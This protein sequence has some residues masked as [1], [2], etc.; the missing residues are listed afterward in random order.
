[1]VREWM[2]HGVF[3]G[4]APL[5]GMAMILGWICISLAGALRIRLASK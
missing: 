2:G 1:G 4:A 5:G 3:P